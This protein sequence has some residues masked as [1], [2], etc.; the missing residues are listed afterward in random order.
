MTSAVKPRRRRTPLQW[1]R[2][3]DS[4]RPLWWDIGLP[5]GM[6]LTTFPSLVANAWFAPSGDDA[7]LV[8][9]PLAVLVW[10][11]HLVPL[12]W[13]RRFPFQVLLVQFVPIAIAITASMDMG[14]ALALYIAL[15]NVSLRCPPN[16]FLAFAGLYIAS[17]FY[18]SILNGGLF[19]PGTFL[20]NGMVPALM[21]AMGG[22]LLR[23]R[24]SF[25]A[26][27]RQ[28]AAEQAVVEERSRI[29]QEMHDIIGH[30]L[31]VITSLSDGGAYAARSSPERAEQA[32]QAIGSASREALTELR[33]VLGVLQ[34][35]DENAPAELSPQPGLRNLEEL[36]ERVRE[37]GI[38]VRLR[39]RGEPFE[40]TPGKE[41][42]VYRTVQESLT[43]VL[44]HA[45]EPTDVEVCLDSTGEDIAVSVSNT[46]GVV[47][48]GPESVDGGQGVAGMERRAR[49]YGGS[50]KAGPRSGGGWAVSLLIPREED[51]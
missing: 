36:V 44:R 7:E 20:A 11:L 30:N 31:A 37:T 28:Q 39:Y 4:R 6:M 25:H 10:L 19:V 35:R 29:A 14:S 45:H 49:A 17:I 22:W 27:Q 48:P 24:R 3:F 8:P 42:A 33:R 32:L 1:V 26:A 18:E 12:V 9:L 2:D 40:L 15:F 23:S 47:L 41:L 46:G 51:Q 43:N 50:L 13:R 38:P 16:R 5:L 34:A 21:V